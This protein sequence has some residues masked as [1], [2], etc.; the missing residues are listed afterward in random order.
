M[1]H[2]EEVA[3]EYL[4]EIRDYLIEVESGTIWTEAYGSRGTGEDAF[5]NVKA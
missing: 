1:E 3:D 4:K 5:F 2:V